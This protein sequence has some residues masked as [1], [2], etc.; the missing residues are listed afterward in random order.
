MD[1]D[2]CSN[3]SVTAENTKILLIFCAGMSGG[4]LVGQVGDVGYVLPNTLKDKLYDFKN[5]SKAVNVNP[6]FIIGAGGG[7]WCSRN[8]LPEVI[9]NLKY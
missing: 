6:A 9:Y 5:V 1:A 7:N 3:N 8:K 2:E 4:E